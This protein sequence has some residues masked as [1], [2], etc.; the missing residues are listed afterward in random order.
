MKWHID[1]SKI[2]ITNKIVKCYTDYGD[3]NYS[4]EYAINGV[5]IADHYLP[6][7]SLYCNNILHRA[8]WYS[9]ITREREIQLYYDYTNSTYIMRN[10]I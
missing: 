1:P 3:G 2:V 4:V 7:Y 9:N 5:F 10:Y 8:V 6:S